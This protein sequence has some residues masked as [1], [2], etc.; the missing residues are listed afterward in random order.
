MDWGQ[1]QIGT[2]F[3]EIPII[4]L[5]RQTVLWQIVVYGEVAYIGIIQYL[6]ITQL[7]NPMR[8]KRDRVDH[9]WC[10]EHI[11]NLPWPFQKVNFR[12]DF[13]YMK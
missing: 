5:T 13:L 12:L 4:M 3:M 9:I 6:P 7:I 2:D 8:T 1:L 11:R 10:M